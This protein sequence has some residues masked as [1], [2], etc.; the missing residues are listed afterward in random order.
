MWG[1]GTKYSY[2]PGGK[3][4]FN[5]NG[6]PGFDKVRSIRIW[7]G[8]L[9]S[10]ATATVAGA[11]GNCPAKVWVHS[12]TGCDL[13]KKDGRK[14]PHKSNH[15]VGTAND[16][17][18]IWIPGGCAAEVALAANG[19]GSNLKYSCGKHCFHPNPGNDKVRSIRVWSIGDCEGD[20]W[21]HD[22]SG[23]DLNK[24]DGRKGPYRGNRWQHTS[25]KLDTI[26]LPEGC[27]AEVAMGYNGEGETRQYGPGGKHCFG[28]KGGPGYDKV[29]S[30]RIWK[31]PKCGYTTNTARRGSFSIRAIGYWSLMSVNLFVSMRI[32]DALGK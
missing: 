16:L 21:G 18:T 5:G 19:G 1:A 13:N 32:T 25:Q 4:C 3:H 27:T 9:S 28:S 10:G 22:L 26:W 30:I 12:S 17:D 31:G 23:C 2:G 29:R 20:T 6:G 14:G 15:W 24:Q 8:S 11:G 7:K